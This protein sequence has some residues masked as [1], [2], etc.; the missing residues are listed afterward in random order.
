[1]KL[2]RTDLSNGFIDR[3]FEIPVDSL[4]STDLNF[5]SQ[6][7]QCMIS[8]ESATF[9]YRIKGQLSV[10]FIYEC[11]RCL[12]SFS[13]DRTIPL[14]IWITENSDFSNIEEVDT[15]FFSPSADTVDLSPTIRDLIQVEKPVKCL[16][17]PG[18]KGLC[19][20]CGNNLNHQSCTCSE[21]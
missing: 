13:D 19:I 11:D 21:N 6:S 3:L 1:M 16:C 8:C 7:I 18:C 9:G 5:S 20:E 17:N 12:D 2:F 10:L 15:I 14:S 4:D